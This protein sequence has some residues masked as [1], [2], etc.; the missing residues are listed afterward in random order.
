[1]STK[2]SAIARVNQARWAELPFCSVQASAL[3]AEILTSNRFVAVTDRLRSGSGL[4]R[5]SIAS[6]YQ[7]F[8]DLMIDFP[9]YTKT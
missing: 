3:L 6:G 5:L 9:I 4:K 8:K 7:N 2:L 1:M